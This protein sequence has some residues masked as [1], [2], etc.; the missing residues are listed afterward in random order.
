[1][2]DYKDGV[3]QN[4][5]RLYN[6]EIKITMKTESGKLTK[7]EEPT[8]VLNFHNFGN[9]T[10]LK[11]EW[12][13]HYRKNNIYA[14]NGKSKRNLECSRESREKNLWDTENTIKR[15]WK[16][17]KETKETKKMK[18]SLYIKREKNQA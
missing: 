18:E 10:N 1:M 2:Y 15:N 17:T 8:R 7:S 12:S 11:D 5:H 4:D 16:V 6:N 14:R 9:N 3:K 13:N